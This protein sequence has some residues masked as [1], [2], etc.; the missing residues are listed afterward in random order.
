MIWGKNDVGTIIGG[1]DLVTIDIP[2]PDFAT[3]NGED[4]LR[5][6]GR[7][8][9]SVPTPVAEWYKGTPLSVCPTN[10]LSYHK[11]QKQS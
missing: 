3:R 1:W 6:E 10:E 9:N 4:V 5:I 2:L 7:E 8:T 11:I